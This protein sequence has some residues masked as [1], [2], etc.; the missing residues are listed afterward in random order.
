MLQLYFPVFDSPLI[1]LHF[2]SSTT[3]TFRLEP[4][5]K[6]AL[7]KLAAKKNLTKSELLRQLTFNEINRL[8]VDEAKIKDDSII[9]AGAKITKPDIKDR[10]VKIPIELMNLVEKEALS[11]GMVKSRWIAALIQS[12]LTKKIV[13]SEKEYLALIESNR[14]LRAI[15]NNLNQTAKFINTNKDAHKLKLEALQ[16]ILGLIEKNIEKTRLLLQASRDSW[17][18]ED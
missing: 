11:K 3:V 1:F 18:N 8:N 17:N 14:E 12:N 2:M 16:V 4:E 5:T 7:S 15:G 10:V 9:F 13:F 6:T